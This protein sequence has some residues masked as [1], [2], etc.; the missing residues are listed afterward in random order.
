LVLRLGEAEV[1]AQSQQEKVQSSE[2][3]LDSV[4]VTLRSE[5]SERRVKTEALKQAVT[6]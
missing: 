2:V 4:R 5:K 6:L 1:F 3:L